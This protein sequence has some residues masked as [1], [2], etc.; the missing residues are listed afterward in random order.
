MALCE[1]GRVSDMS[2]LQNYIIVLITYICL[3]QFL[4]LSDDDILSADVDHPLFM[5]S[6][7]F[8]APYWPKTKNEYS[9][10]GDEIMR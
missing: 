7:H 5:N 6:D 1:L 9:T 4:L 10:K 8:Y 3:K 2:T